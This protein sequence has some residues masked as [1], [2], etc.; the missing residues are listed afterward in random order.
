[1][2]EVMLLVCH[3]LGAAP[4][5]RQSSHQTQIQLLCN[6]LTPQPSNL[7]FSSPR[8]QRKQKQWGNSDLSIDGK[9]NRIDECTSD[10]PY[11]PALLRFLADVRNVSRPTARIL[12]FQITL[13]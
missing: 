11:P 13:V 9:A 7:P 2:M 12:E 4:F 5:S 8:I 6:L 1:M 3:S 10:R